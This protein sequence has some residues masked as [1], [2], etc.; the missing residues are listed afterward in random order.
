MASLRRAK[1]IQLLKNEGFLSGEAVQLSKLPVKTSALQAVRKARSI[2]FATFYKRA[3]SQGWSK[4][5]TDARY[6]K[7]ILNVYRRHS[8]VVKGRVGHGKLNVWA[9]YRAYEKQNPAETKEDR[10]YRKLARK[11]RRKKGQHVNLKHIVEFRNKKRVRQT[12]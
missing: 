12:H 10:E 4:P 5:K 2:R 1:R 3:A 7:H 6:K 9:M 11:M 8:W